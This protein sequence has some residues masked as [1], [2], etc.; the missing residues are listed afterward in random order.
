MKF[1]RYEAPGET[2][3]PNCEILQLGTSHQY[4]SS[5][6]DVR[7]PCQREEQC[8]HFGV[9]GPGRIARGEKQIPDLSVRGVRYFTPTVTFHPKIAHLYML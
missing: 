1:V 7:K 3:L 2:A 8:P 4:L 9:I 5:V 6:D